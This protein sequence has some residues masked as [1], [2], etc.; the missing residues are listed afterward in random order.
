MHVGPPNVGTGPVKYSFLCV[1]KSQEGEP[2]H[3][4]PY[5]VQSMERPPL[6]DGERRL[7]RIVLVDSVWW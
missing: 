7:T 6:Y 5:V 1:S 4:D 2:I 3:P